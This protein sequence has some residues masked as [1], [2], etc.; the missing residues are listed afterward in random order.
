MFMLR[1]AQVVTPA[2]QRSM[3]FAAVAGI[4]AFVSFPIGSHAPHAMI[5]RWVGEIVPYIR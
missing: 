1:V 2:L 5:A 4:A 3:Q